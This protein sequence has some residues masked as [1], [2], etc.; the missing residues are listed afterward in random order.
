M[1]AVVA[2]SLLL[3]MSRIATIVKAAG[4]RERGEEYQ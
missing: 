3:D 1:G 4:G 2:T